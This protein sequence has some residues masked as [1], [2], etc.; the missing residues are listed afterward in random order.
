MNANDAQVDEEKGAR[1]HYESAALPTELRRPPIDSK[2]E[3]EKRKAEN[4]SSRLRRSR[5]CH[6]LILLLRLRGQ[7]DPHGVDAERGSE[8]DVGKQRNKREH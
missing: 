3:A 6:R 4:R 7:Q 2:W 5:L 1:L 8:W